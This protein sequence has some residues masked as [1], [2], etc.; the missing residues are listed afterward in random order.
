MHEL[1][2]IDQVFQKAKDRNR[3][4]SECHLPHEAIYVRLGEGEV[5]AR[6]PL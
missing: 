6:S 5:C 2:D 4:M 1:G 3:A